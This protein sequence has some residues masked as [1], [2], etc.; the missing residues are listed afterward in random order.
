MASKRKTQRVWLA[1]DRTGRVADWIVYS[2]KR[3]AAANAKRLTS[4]WTEGA[5]YRA[6]K[7]EAKP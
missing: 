1:V 5:P 3:G 6:Q 2:T 7:F 4:Y